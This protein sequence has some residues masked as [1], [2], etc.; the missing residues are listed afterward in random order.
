MP[1]A[2]T[3]IRHLLLATLTLLA[4]TGPA[5]ATAADLDAPCFTIRLPEGWSAEPD[6][7]AVSTGVAGLEVVLTCVRTT[8]SPLPAA[9]R[10]ETFRERLD[11]EA[12]SLPR[13]GLPDLPAHPAAL[14]PL[15]RGSLGHFD[16]WMS[17]T[18]ELQDHT[19]LLRYRLFH[20]RAAI[21]AEI[22]YRPTQQALV[23]RFVRDSLRQARWKPH[24]GWDAAY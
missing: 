17:L 11:N 19:R 16:A 13:V 10:D 1:A 2:L 4:T 20:Q 24:A 12:A 21:A 14:P 9:E 7:L 3:V 6:S 22:R 15:Q 5:H 18:V 23:D 8:G